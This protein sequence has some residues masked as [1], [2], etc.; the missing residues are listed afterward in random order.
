LHYHEPL[1]DYF[2]SPQ[3]VQ[4]VS[5]SKEKVLTGHLLQNV[6]LFTPIY[7]PQGHFIQV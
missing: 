3:L 1:I 4:E 7:V 6:A 2:F 5:P